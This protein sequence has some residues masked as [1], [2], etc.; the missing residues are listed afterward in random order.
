MFLYMRNVFIA[1]IFM[2]YA[3][4]LMGQVDIN[5]T[6]FPD[7]NFRGIVTGNTI[8]DDGDGELSSSEIQGVTKLDVSSSSISNLIGIEHF[9]TL[10]TLNCSSNSLT[11]LDVRSNTDLTNLNCS[12]NSL[13]SL[14][15]SKILL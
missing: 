1:S 15:V 10:T 12:S 7:A 8:D 6:N 2:I 13:T 9:S 4:C 14:D 11:E 3:T 5:D